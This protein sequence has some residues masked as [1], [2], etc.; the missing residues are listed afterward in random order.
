M[1]AKKDIK[2]F[3][4]PICLLNGAFDDIHTVTDNIIDYSI[5][6][7][8]LKLDLGTEKNKMQAALD[9]YELIPGNI[10]KMTDNGK[11]LNNSKSERTALTSINRDMV[12]D[13]YKN[14]KSEFDIACFC[15]FAAIKSILGKKE[16]CKTN[17]EFII[18]RAFSYNSISDVPE[19]KPI[20][21]KKYSKRYHIDL[22]LIE[23]QTNWGLS[24]FS[25]HSRG[26]YLSFKLDIIELAKIN[27]QSKKSTKFNEL[28][29]KKKEALIT[30]RQIING[31]I[32]TYFYINP[33][34]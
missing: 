4:F 19:I 10:K 16:F 32:D 9:F 12:F 23:L 34:S 22:V 13:F 26:F 33:T 24:L 31:N 27:I 28:R 5:Y 20:L 11:M 21:F 17:K 6:K 29:N 14:Y 30:A 7:H 2:Y 18:S 8:S 3:T 15:T 1:G 25:D